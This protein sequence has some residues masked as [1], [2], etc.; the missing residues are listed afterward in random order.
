M[1]TIISSCTGF[2][3]TYHPENHEAGHTNAS[4]GVAIVLNGRETCPIH[5]G[6]WITQRTGSCGICKPRYV[7]IDCKVCIQACGGGGATNS[8]SSV[9]AVGAQDVPNSIEPA[10]ILPLP[11]RVEL[12]L[13]KPSATVLS[14]PPHVPTSIKPPSLHPRVEP[15][16]QKLPFNSTPQRCLCCSRDAKN[17]VMCCG[18]VCGYNQC[19]YRDQNGER[20]KKPCRDNPRNVMCVHHAG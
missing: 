15:D 13:A 3:F 18:D 20:C 4:I 5:N 11:P 12:D 14:S 9:N 1:G 16:L 17:G 8:T 6:I 2:G 7:Q 10:L 19:Q